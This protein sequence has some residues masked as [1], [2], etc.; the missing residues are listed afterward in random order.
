[1]GCIRVAGVWL[2]MMGLVAMVVGAGAGTAWGAAKPEPKPVIL[3]TDI[4]DDI[5]DTWALALLLQSPELEAKLIV[6]AV[7][8]TEAKARVVAKF[9][10]RVGRSDIPVGIGIKQNDGLGRQAAWAKD[11]NLNGY[12]G[13]VQK[14]G[15]QAMIDVVMK[16]PRRVTIIGIGPLTNVA[17]ALAKEPRIA[18]KVDFVGM[19]GSIRKGYGDKAT[20]E[21]E[22]NVKTDA[23]ACRKVF[24]APW[25]VTITPLDTCGLVQLGGD[26]Y[27]KV[28]TRSSTLTRTLLENYRQWLEDGIRNERKDIAPTELYL[29]ASTPMSRGSTTLFDTVAIYLAINTDLAKMESLPIQITD[30]GS[31]R[32]AEGA[33]TINCATGWKN[34]AGF[35]DFLVERLTK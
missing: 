3:D 5:D 21:P 4:C 15:V 31:T 27:M 6:T 8:N 7:G 29:Q 9:L 22:Y 12:L 17:A 34:L 14:D 19:Q 26:K 13:G 25:N 28:L 33:K 11:Y 10:E 30:D 32:I 16:S 18:E 2:R 1:M 23:A 24:A 20:P 35:E